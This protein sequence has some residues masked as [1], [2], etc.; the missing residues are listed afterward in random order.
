MSSF[1]LYLIGTLLVIGGLT[2]VTW[3][4]HT[5]TTWLIAGVVV[6]VGLGIVGA[7]K[8]TRRRDPPET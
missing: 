2:Y 7:V 6:M 4:L 1:A 3:M 8:S 5:P